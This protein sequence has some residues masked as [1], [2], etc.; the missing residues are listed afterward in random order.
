MDI[1]GVCISTLLCYLEQEGYLEIKH[2]TMD[3]CTL[4]C[5]GGQNHLMALAEKVPIVKAAV[6]EG[7]NNGVL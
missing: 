1:L 7:Y 4:K 3:K 2:V 5:S 6:K